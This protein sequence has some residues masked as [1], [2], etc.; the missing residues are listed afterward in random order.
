MTELL[1]NKSIKPE[2]YEQ[3]VKLYL[4]CRS[5]DESNIFNF[6]DSKRGVVSDILSISQYQ[7]KIEAEIPLSEIIE[8]FNSNI[9]SM[10]QGYGNYSYEND[11]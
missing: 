4:F 6:I 7:S 8:N 11:A 3:Y 5:E 10:T 1:K 2:F 9:K